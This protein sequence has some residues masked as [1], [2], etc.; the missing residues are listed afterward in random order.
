MK[1]KDL[2][3]TVELGS[4]QHAVERLTDDLDKAHKELERLRQHLID[5]EDTNAEE[6]LEREQQQEALNAKYDP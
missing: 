3:S 4:A 5:V 1:Q 6:A 2:A